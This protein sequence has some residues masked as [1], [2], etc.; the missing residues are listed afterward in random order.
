MTL[1]KIK[2]RKPSKATKKTSRNNW[3]IFAVGV[4]PNVQIALH[5]HT[6]IWLDVVSECFILGQTFHI[7][8]YLLVILAKLGFNE[9]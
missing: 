5:I 6:Y 3:E 7:C 2:N 4:G 8:E 9:C 1:P